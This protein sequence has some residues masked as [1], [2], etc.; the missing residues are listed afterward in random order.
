VRVTEPPDPV[1]LGDV[2][3]GLNPE[4]YGVKMVQI[5]PLVSSALLPQIYVRRVLEA[6]PQMGL[7]ADEVG[8]LLVGRGNSASGEP[9]AV[10]R[11]QEAKFQQNVKQALVNEGFEERHVAVGWLRNPPLLGDALMSLVAAGCK[12]VYWMPSSYSADGISTLFDV[13]VQLSALAKQHG[14]RL[15]PLG[16][17]NGDELAAEEIAT[18]VRAAARVTAGR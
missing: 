6:L 5:G 15:V 3:E 10:R 16:G 7:H 1:R 12:S 17:W 14:V 2:L 13:P 11:E 8:L 18:R 4:A 9:A